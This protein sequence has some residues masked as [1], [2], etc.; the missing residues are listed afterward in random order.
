MTAARRILLVVSWLYVLGVIVQFFLAGL[1]SLG[2]DDF[3][4][5]EAMGYAALHFSPILIL[6]VAYLGKVSRTTIL[7][8]LA[9]VVV[10][11][12][13]PFWVTSFQG[14]T[15]GAMHVLGALVIF[16]LAHHI[17]QRSTRELHASS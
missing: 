3:E 13:Q 6:V 2:G 14:E 7:L 11:F 17:A 15:L 9:L 10:A 4:A 8:A 1:G 5:H 12:V 16:T